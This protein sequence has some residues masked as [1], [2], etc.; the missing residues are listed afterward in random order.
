MNS[1]TCRGY[2]LSYFFLC[3]T[4]SELLQRRKQRT[5]GY[6]AYAFQTHQDVFIFPFEHT[7]K[8]KSVQYAV[9]PK[10]CIQFK[11]I[12][13]RGP[14]VTIRL[15]WDPVTRHW[16]WYMT[17]YRSHCTS[18][19]RLDTAQFLDLCEETQCSFVSTYFLEPCLLSMLIRRPQL[20]DR[21][22]GG[23]HPD[24]KYLYVM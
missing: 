22:T 9:T 14:P 23:F 20:P 5:A 3:L 18:T 10:S 15:E 6:K 19:K 13:N 8:Q 7:S 16:T 4:F 17:T 1:K 21:T 2:I 12:V 11:H 24:D